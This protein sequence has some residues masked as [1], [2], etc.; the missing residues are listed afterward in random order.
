MSQITENESQENVVVKTFDRATGTFSDATPQFRVGSGAALAKASKQLTDADRD[1]VNS[2]GEK[3]TKNPVDLT[4]TDNTTGATTRI[5]GDVT[6]GLDSTTTKFHA[7]GTK[8]LLRVALLRSGCTR[9]HLANS[10]MEALANDDVPAMCALMGVDEDALAEVDAFIK[11]M[12]EETRRP[13]KGRTSVTN[14]TVA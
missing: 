8:N 7:Y 3:I 6:I 13:L 9:G 14:L 11:T 12:G 4:V 10:L 5:T 2:A 1:A